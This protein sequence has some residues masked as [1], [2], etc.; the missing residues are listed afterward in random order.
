MRTLKVLGTL[1]VLSGLIQSGSA[2]A[3]DEG[4]GGN[5][6]GAAADNAATASLVEA[7][8]D[9]S[10]EAVVCLPG[11]KTKAG[12]SCAAPGTGDDAT[13]PDPFAE[14]TAESYDGGLASSGPVYAVG[15]IR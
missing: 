10:S 8:A 2:F 1:V 5:A 7:P 4:G 9:A 15:G 14:G 13:P 3:Q 11:G 6:D 12:A